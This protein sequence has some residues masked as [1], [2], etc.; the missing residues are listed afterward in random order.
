[1]QNHFYVLHHSN[2]NVSQIYGCTPLTLLNKAASAQFNSSSPGQNGCDFAD[3][4]LKCIFM[5]EKF[6]TLIRISLK[7]ISIN[8]KQ[9]LVQVMAWRRGNADPVH[10]RI[11]AALGGDGLILHVPVM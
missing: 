7:L 2:G 1:M 4:I 3:D 8:N 11:Y 10:C 5:N 6:C 9:L